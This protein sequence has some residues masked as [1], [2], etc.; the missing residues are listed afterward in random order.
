MVSGRDG[1]QPS[2]GEIFRPRTH[3]VDGGYLV[4][5]GRVEQGVEPGGHQ[6]GVNPSGVVERLLGCRGAPLG[7]ALVEQRG[8]EPNAV[9]DADAVEPRLPESQ[10]ILEVGARSFAGTAKPG[11][12]PGGDRAGTGVLGS[13]KVRD[14]FGDVLAEPVR[15][16]LIGA[17]ADFQSLRIVYETRVTGGDLRHETDGSTDMA[18]WHPLEEVPALDRVGLV[19]IG[20]TL[21]R[22]RPAV[23]RSPGISEPPPA[24]LPA[25]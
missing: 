14:P 16:K 21:W 20:L 10:R 18:A 19:D 7:L 23:G 25:G 9:H 4:G 13:V 24:P 11:E 6:C 1:G 15:H 5:A 3:L 12:V 2:G 8:G 22:K 17:T